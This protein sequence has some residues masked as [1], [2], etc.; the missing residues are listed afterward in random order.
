MFE[1][2]KKNKVKLIIS[3]IIILLPAI[4]GLILWDDLPDKYVS[5]WN[6]GGE[7][8]RWAGKA[9]QVFAVPC[10]T[11]VLHWVCVLISFADSANKNQGNKLWR[12]V[13][14]LCPATSIYVNAVTY[15]AAMGLDI[16]VESVTMAFVGLTF[17]IIGNYLPKCKQ[18][19][20]IGI[21]LVWTLRSEENWNRTHRL[22]GKLWTACGFVFLIS[23]FMPHII[24]AILHP[25][26]FVF[27]IIVPVIYSFSFYKKQCR[28]G[29]NAE[30]EQDLQTYRR[31]AK[32]AKIVAVIIAVIM[33][34]VG[35]LLFTGDIGVEYGENSFTI[36]ADYWQDVEVSYDLIDS[37][38][39]R[40]GDEPGFRE[41]GF[42][43]VRLMMGTFS[44]D[45]FGR[46][47]RYTYRGCKT[48]VV[49]KSAD[50]TLVV[51]GRN[52]EET[53]RIYERLLECSHI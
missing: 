9:F 1:L 22:C 45:E 11:F 31:S 8:D 53:K 20:T 48:C 3:S 35:W 42:G 43:S 29:L 23:I 44:N 38:E 25:V 12:V 51:N 19:S 52:D 33:I 49:L 14:F 6:I 28:D 24:R 37:I 34:A 27:V 47:T 32:F 7:A 18:N 5:H 36:Q 13:L 2:I 21:K 26:L 16:S 50:K 10:F 4:A 30:E 39:Y 40:T 17:I 41:A 15:S 46:Y